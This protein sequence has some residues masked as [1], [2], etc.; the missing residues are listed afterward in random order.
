M[1][2]VP[3]IVVVV[4]EYAL[5]LA[6]LGYLAWLLFSARG[7]AVR[8]RPAALPAWNVTISD[9]LFL[10]W[11]I[12]LLGVLGQLLL[13]T[14]AG[15]LPGAQSDVH[16]LELLLYGS[17]FHFGAVLTWP[18]ARAL[19]RRY[20]ADLF[21]PI[22]PPTLAAALPVVHGS[23]LAFLA[24]M[25]LASGLGLAW[26]QILQAV[27]LPTERQELVDLILQAKSATLLAFLITLAL[28]LAPIAEELVFRAGI[29]RFLRTRAP[30]WVAYVVSAGLFAALHGYWSSSLPLF[31]LGLVFAASYER[32]GR[33]A[34]PMLAHALFNLNTLLL[35]LSG[36][37]S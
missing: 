34:V 10:G 25:P 30:R 4:F 37:G 26:E 33:I 23:F 16:T 9:L 3:Q 27:G 24:A 15:P 19:S 29:F 11:L 21:Q 13:R 36:V 6:G 1:L 20:R 7:R 22:A 5:A 17:M 35:V 28:V 14:I 18:L 12:L 31:V 2:S 8:A 32:T